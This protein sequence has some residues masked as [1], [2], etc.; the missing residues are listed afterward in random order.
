[1]KMCHHVSR[2]PRIVGVVGTFQPDP[3]EAA[4][5]GAG[6]SGRLEATALEVLSEALLGADKELC[7]KVG[8]G[9]FRRRV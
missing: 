9:D 7:P 8:D 1:M 4:L 6:L 5:P 3:I 2:G